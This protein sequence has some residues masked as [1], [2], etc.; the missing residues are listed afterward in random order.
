MLK[1]I[2]AWLVCALLIATQA[3]RVLAAEEEAK[4][5][6][7][8]PE[9]VVEEAD[10]E[11]EEEEEEAP[12]PWVPP[13]HILTDMPDPAD[14]VVVSCHLP[15]IAKDSKFR[16]GDIVDAL[17][18]LS[19]EGELPVTVTAVAGAFVHP[20]DPSVHYQNFS[21]FPYNVTVFPQDT[22]TVLYKFRSDPRLEPRELGMF[23]RIF[24]RDAEGTNFST[25]A[26]NGTFIL[27]EFPD[28][29]DARTFFT[30]TGVAAAVVL[31]GIVFYK[32]IKQTFGGP[33][34]GQAKKSGATMDGNE[35]LPQVVTEW[36]RT[37]A[38]PR[39][40]RGSASPHK[41]E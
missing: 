19:N 39:R 10:D 29:V 4:A 2:L 3:R 23:L 31:L 21:E 26:F 24:Y 11:E 12:K 37:A 32:P 34:S 20:L 28:K 1:T 14:D 22:W 40:T 36:E 6:A 41:N 15:P 8:E 7:A 9:A 5:S 38:R 18:G 13:P 33:K 30:Y 17:I 16:P 35:Y 25:T 27:S